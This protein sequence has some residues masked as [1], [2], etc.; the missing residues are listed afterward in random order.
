MRALKILVVA[1][2][3]VLGVCGQKAHAAAASPGV[4][5]AAYD[6]SAEANT[7][8]LADYGARPDVKKLPDGLMYRVLRAGD[9]PQPQKNSDVATVYYKGSLISGQVFDQ[10][11]PEE[12][13]PLQVGGVIPGWTEALK[14]MK[15][16]DTWEL[17]IPSDLAYGSDGVADSIPADQTLVFLVSLAKVEYGP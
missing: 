13:T 3:V 4:P 12:P 10:T 6:T 15:T 9:G 2:L 8:F 16:G 1:S 7:R 5:G 11:K 14:L 17:V